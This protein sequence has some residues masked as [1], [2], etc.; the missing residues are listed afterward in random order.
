[1]TQNF[2]SL[3]SNLTHLD[4]QGQAQMV[5]VS[6]KTSTIRQA[7]AAASVRMLPET[8]LPFKQETPQKV[9][10]WELPG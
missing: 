10:C 4:N 8:L 2:Q 3:S 1:M 9:M 6:A 5:D 7:V